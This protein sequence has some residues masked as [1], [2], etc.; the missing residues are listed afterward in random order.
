MDRLSELS[1]DILRHVLSFLVD[2]ESAARTSI[3]SGRWRPL[4]K[5]V[6]VLH[7]YSSTS[8]F[9]GNFEHKLVPLRSHRGNCVDISFISSG[10]EEE[11]AII[12]GRKKPDLVHASFGKGVV[13]VFDKVLERCA[14]LRA[15]SFRKWF[16]C[17]DL[18]RMASSIAR[19]H[20]SESL[21]ALEF[22]G[23]FL[24]RGDLEAA[25][26]PS[27]P[28]VT[29]LEL[30]GCDISYFHHDDPFAILPRLSCLKLVGCNRIYLS[31]SIKISGLELRSLEIRCTDVCI[32]QLAAPKLESLCYSGEMEHLGAFQEANL[33]SL[34]RASVS[35]EYR[36]ST[37]LDG[38]G[39]K[40]L[41]HGLRYAKS[42][43]LCIKQTFT[44]F[45]HHLPRTKSLLLYLKTE[46]RKS[47][48]YSDLFKM[49]SFIDD[50]I[51]R[52][53]RL[54]TFN[55]RYPEEFIISLPTNENDVTEDPEACDE[56]DTDN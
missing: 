47:Q 20:H 25:C 51:S 49:K 30:R 42:L 56:V 2:I 23:C 3:L 4:W 19:H 36:K 33:P 55:I 18:G 37:E 7:L 32:T 31:D 41:L 48:E 50:E 12:V 22:V 38:Q 29:T 54:K 11:Y 52:F 40:S 13:D 26:E 35:M 44:S 34:C 6:P 17:D 45:F 16:L 15:L 5:D 8:P 9:T 14:S 21:E 28:M 1:D 27:F 46:Y 53:T 24:L 43:D 39:F 10:K